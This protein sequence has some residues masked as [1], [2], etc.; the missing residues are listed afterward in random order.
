MNNF[1]D[2][3]GIKSIRESSKDF[4][5]FGRSNAQFISTIFIAITSIWYLSKTYSKLRSDVSAQEK[6]MK[7]QIEAAEAKIKTARAEAIQEC[8]DKFLMYGYAAEYQKYQ[9]KALGQHSD[10]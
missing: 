9:Q 4:L 5:R 8:N 1:I 6:I 7:A 10:K 2:D 3:H